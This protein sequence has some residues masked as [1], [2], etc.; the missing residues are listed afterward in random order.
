MSKCPKTEFT[1]FHM[2]LY[3]NGISEAQ[4][5]CPKI[6]KNI[7]FLVNIKTIFSYFVF[8]V[9]HCF[10]LSF[11][12]S[13]VPN[14]FVAI[15]SNEQKKIRYKRKQNPNVR[16]SSSIKIA[17]GKEKRHPYRFCKL[18]VFDSRALLKP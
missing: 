10:C 11:H 16:R 14:A 1:Y 15:K 8:F 2:S 17:R 12:Q 13:N 6:D 7:L 18:N 5:F 4:L 3:A 9:R